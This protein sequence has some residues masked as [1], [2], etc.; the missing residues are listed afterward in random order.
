[1]A[2]AGQRGSD[3]SKPARNRNHTENS[4]ADSR[5]PSQSLDE[6]ASS[7]HPYRY[8]GI[9]DWVATRIKTLV[10]NKLQACQAITEAEIALV[11]ASVY[12]SNPSLDSHGIIELIA[13]MAQTFVV[14]HPFD[15]ILER[16]RLRGMDLYKRPFTNLASSPSRTLVRSGT[17]SSLKNSQGAAPVDELADSG[18]AHREPN[19]AYPR[20]KALSN[21]ERTASNTSVTSPDGANGSALPASISIRQLAEQ[22]AAQPLN[23]TS[24][25]SLQQLTPRVISD[26]LKGHPTSSGS[27]N[28]PQ[29]VALDKQSPGSDRVRVM[30]HNPAS[31][32]LPVTTSKDKDFFGTPTEL[33]EMSNYLRQDRRSSPLKREDFQSNK[34]LTIEHISDCEVNETQYLTLNAQD[35]TQMSLRDNSIFSYQS[36]QRGTPLAFD[37]LGHILEEENHSTAVQN[38]TPGDQSCDSRPLVCSQRSKLYADAVNHSDPGAWRTSI[39]ADN[40]DD[41]IPHPQAQRKESAYRQMLKLSSHST[42]LQPALYVTDKHS[43]IVLDKRAHEDPVDVFGGSEN[44]TD[45]VPL[46]EDIAQRFSGGSM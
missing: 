37:G 46:Y 15:L 44:S 12:Y 3:T 38:G 39:L 2:A 31:N 34:L 19:V 42:L 40:S 10:A 20:H 16:N 22:Q 41:R 25:G 35:M 4:L 32:R 7:K 33:R 36:G 24:T 27:A 21:Q 6:Y 43:T 26:V 11:F 17:G 1:M 9:P 29:C 45:S 18:Q 5:A 8:T 14:A 28:T 23:M 13:D 30:R